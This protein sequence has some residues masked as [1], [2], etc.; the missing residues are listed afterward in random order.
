MFFSL[1][2]RVSHGPTCEPAASLKQSRRASC[3]QRCLAALGTVGTRCGGTPGCSFL[4]DSLP[5]SPPAN[6]VGLACRS[7]KDRQVF[8][9]S[10]G[11][12]ESMRAASFP[13][14]GSLF[15]FERRIRVTSWGG[16]RGS[17]YC[18]EPPQPR[19]PSSFEFGIGGCAGPGQYQLTRCGAGGLELLTI[20]FRRLASVCGL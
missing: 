17:P 11:L 8:L 1:S 10:K 9:Y 7:L 13:A 4:P 19:I 20:P 18:P 6:P 5:S 3:R 14:R 2:R 16:G 15:F 12:S